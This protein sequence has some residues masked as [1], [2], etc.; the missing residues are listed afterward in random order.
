MFD[1]TSFLKK[2]GTS[3]CFGL[4]VAFA[5][6]LAAIPVQSQDKKQTQRSGDQTDVIKVT[7]NLVNLDVI[8]KDKKGKA[9]T[10]LKPEDFTITENG[11]RQKIEFFDSALVG[12]E[13]PDET[14]VVTSA[15]VPRQPGSLPRNI[16][17]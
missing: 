9:I 7:S 17:A 4:L 1:D 3:L 6:F 10:D 12:A 14:P 15:P 2:R 13:V 8:V 11:V 5:I 16:I